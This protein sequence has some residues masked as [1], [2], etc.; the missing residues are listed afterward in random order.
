MTCRVSHHLG[1]MFF[2]L[3]VL[4]EFALLFSWTWIPRSTD[5]A[6]RTGTG[7][8]Q[9]VVKSS[10]RHLTP[11]SSPRCVACGRQALPFASRVAS[12]PAGD[13][14]RD[15]TMDTRSSGHLLC[16]SWESQPASLEISRGC[17]SNG[18][19]VS[20]GCVY[21]MNRHRTGDMLL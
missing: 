14:D 9:L 8:E 18:T 3:C 2:L 19:C 4:R 21:N 17:L 10:P 11:A 12:G 13:T 1:C 6:C 15:L 16:R 20:L 7:V 5:R